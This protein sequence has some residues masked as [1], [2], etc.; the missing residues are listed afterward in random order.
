M[1]L[2]FLP[3]SDFKAFF[4]IMT[5]VS[6]ILFMFPFFSARMIPTMAKVGLSLII[7]VVLYPVTPVDTSIFPDKGWEMALLI[8]G[9]MLIGMILGLL[10]Q[11]F[12]EG[13]RLM[14]QLTGF[15]TGFAIS[16]VLDP[17][18]GNQV[19]IFANTAY[20]VSLIIF[21][22]LNGHHIILAAMRES[23][24]VITPGA[25]QINEKVFEQILQKSGDMFA[26]ALKIGAP[27]IAALLFVKMAFGLVTK[28]IPQMNIMIVAFPVQIVIGLLFFGISLGVL[29]RHMERYLGDLDNVLMN[30]MAMIRV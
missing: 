12:F 15:Q 14:G 26:I 20:W 27:A 1:D 21:L 29:L 8:T 19:S 6:V 13:I 30:T 17:V 10:L 2:G 9:E 4:L 28:F 25:V 11:L 22:L 3:Y 23:F 5:R 18:S 24:E 7:A 16:N